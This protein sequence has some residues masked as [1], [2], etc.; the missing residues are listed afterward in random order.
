MTLP[1]KYTDP[2]LR[3]TLTLVEYPILSDRI[4]EQMRQWLFDMG[5][6]TIQDFEAMVREEAIRSQG[7]EGLQ[8]PFGDESEEVW[9]KR[10]ERV[11]KHL[12]DFYFATNVPYEVF[13]ELLRSALLIRKSGDTEI[14]ISFNPELAP[15]YILFE[16]AR[17]IEKMP[18]EQKKQHQ[19]L[20]EEIKVVLIRV[21]ISDQLGYVQIAKKWF[22]VEDLVKIRARKIG[23]GKVGGKAAGMLL[24]MS[25]LRST[26]KGDDRAHLSFPESY[27]LGSDLMYTFMTVN[28]LMGWND[29]KYKPEDVIREEYPRVV[30]RFLRGEFPPD[31]TERMERMLEK[32]SGKPLIVRSSSQLEDNFGTSFAGKYDSFFCPNQGTPKEN[33]RALVQ[34]IALVYASTLNPDALL[35]RRSKGLQDYDERMAI[36]IQVVDGKQLG[37]YFYPQLA[38]VAFSRNLYR[39]DPR[40]KRDDGFLRLVW[41]LGTRAVD[42]V[43]NDYP[44]LVALSHPMLRPEANAQA[45]R[46]YSQQYI[47]LLDMEENKITTLAVSDVLTSKCSILRYIAQL[48]KEGYLAPIRSNLLPK[49]AELVLTFNDLLKRTRFADKMREILQILEKSYRRPVDLEFTA[50]I[51]EPNQANPAIEISILQCR[52]QSHVDDVEVQLPNL[53]D[54]DILFS[55]RRMVPRGHVYDI[56]YV[57][58]VTPENYYTLPTQSERLEVGRAV[59]RINQAMEDK[60]FICIGPGRWGTSNT[61]LGVRVGYSD[62]YHASALVEV[63]GESSGPAPEPSFGTHFFQDLM[64][65]RTYPLAIY[66][67]D[68][69]VIF[70]R[71]FLYDTPNIL[72]QFLSEEYLNAMPHI[73]QCVRVVD[74]EDIRP[75]HRLDLVMDDEEGRAVAFLK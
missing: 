61:E 31:I 51:P 18:L 39:W 9:D 73:R 3:I 57:V 64:E 21:M 8:D 45:I 24:A 36:L 44:R 40:I 60:T 68:T 17:V 16:Q 38:G 15:K 47:D 6:I 4:R 27:F 32:L 23:Y 35:Y 75:N 41:G 54:A 22:S 59:G 58:F 67:A 62:I 52:P 19:A 63:T 2:I 14:A 66:L 71:A 34:A 72:S 33:L 1:S 11:R 42:R 29:Q 43:G 5:I 48:Y 26:L 20:L 25:I 13:E 50:Y 7:R 56:R 49:D 69:D 65:S 55:T 46:R 37:R 10:V 53:V 74:V 12:T 28:G 70:N 30:K